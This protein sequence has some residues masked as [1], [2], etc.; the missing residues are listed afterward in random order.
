[1][2]KYH[3]IKHHR[4][5]IPQPTIH[6]L[7]L[8]L[9]SLE[10][11]IETEEG[12]ERDTI[13][14]SEI[15]EITG[16]HSDQIRKDLTYFGEFGK[17]GIGYPVKELITALKLILGSSRKWDIVIAGAGNLGEALVRYKGFQKRGFHFKAI[18]DNEPSKIGKVFAGIKIRPI[19]DMVDYIRKMKVKVGIIAVPAKSAQE[20]TDYMIAGGI[21]SI[22]NFAPANL[23]CPDDVR[24]NSIDISI[25][26]ERLVFFLTSEQKQNGNIRKKSLNFPL[27][28]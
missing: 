16:I 9:R 22:L 6:R 14:S 24:I 21:Q 18:F 12:R 10:T 7:S 19:G 27:D 4:K 1:M 26:L 17:R 5:N 28:L 15:S 3:T 8:C 25:E 23:K 2:R 11:W 20:V 13:S